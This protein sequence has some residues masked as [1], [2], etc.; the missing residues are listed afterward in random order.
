MNTANS[1]QKS[2]EIEIETREEHGSSQARRSRRDGFIPSVVY[3]RG[4]QAVSVRVQEQAF[5]QMAQ[6]ARSSQVFIFKSSNPELNNRSAIVKKIQKNHLDGKLLHVD[7]QK[8][9]YQGLH[10]S[11]GGGRSA[12][13]GIRGIRRCRRQTDAG[14]IAIPGTVHS[15]VMLVHDLGDW[16]C[17]ATRCR[18]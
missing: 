6:L 16:P 10:D 7:F 18:R 1:S 4:E 8:A 3:A 11:D 9:F 14:R 15:F 12:E 13:P 17:E 5:V 2:F